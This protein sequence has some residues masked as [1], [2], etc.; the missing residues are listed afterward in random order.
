MNTLKLNDNGFRL[1]VNHI[2][3]FSDS[4]LP[5]NPLENTPSNARE[6][7]N[8]KAPAPDLRIF[9][10]SSSDITRHIPINKNREDFLLIVTPILSS[11]LNKYKR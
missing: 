2:L 11:Y 1:A 10:R 6:I 7:A 4:G 5:L 8:N 9:K 3:S